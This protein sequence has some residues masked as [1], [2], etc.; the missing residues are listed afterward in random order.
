MKEN[1]YLSINGLTYRPGC[2]T[3]VEIVNCLFQFEG[4]YPDRAVVTAIINSDLLTIFLP[5]IASFVIS[6]FGNNQ[7]QLNGLICEIAKCD[8]CVEPRNEVRGSI[9]KNL[10]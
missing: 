9:V 6:L 8:K 3:L 4:I 2:L 5:N 1:G 7:E 10:C